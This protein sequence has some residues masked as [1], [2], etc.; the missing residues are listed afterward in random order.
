ML[1]LSSAKWRKIVYLCLL[2]HKVMTVLSKLTPLAP[3]Q[4]GTGCVFGLV[5]SLSVMQKVV[6]E[7]SR[8]LD[9]HDYAIKTWGGKKHLHFQARTKHFMRYTLACT[10]WWR[11]TRWDI[12]FEIWIFFMSHKLSQTFKEFS[13]T[14]YLIKWLLCAPRASAKS[15]A[16]LDGPGNSAHVGED[17]SAPCLHVTYLQHKGEA[18]KK[19]KPTT[20][21]RS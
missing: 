6:P 16:N 20:K 11:Q 7:H 17:S 2:G 8:A 12:V 1:Y 21:T 4:D 14:V 19:K 3:H 5:V 10:T 9:I 18:M 15:K 13:V